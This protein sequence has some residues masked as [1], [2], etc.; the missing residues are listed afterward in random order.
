MTYEFQKGLLFK[1]NFRDLFQY[2]TYFHH[3]FVIRSHN[4]Q[5]LTTFLNSYYRKMKSGDLISAY[6]YNSQR[7]EVRR[8][9]WIERTQIS[10]FDFAE[11]TKKISTEPLSREIKQ[12]ITR[13]VIED[14][15]CNTLH[16]VVNFMLEDMSESQEELKQMVEEGRRMGGLTHIC[17]FFGSFK[18]NSISF[19]TGINF[20]RV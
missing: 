3:I 20:I 19:T 2:T 10:T 4:P 7:R 17:T 6:Y 14:T 15:Q 8:M 11:I 5:Q 9:K 13:K 16:Y 18:L 1:W 12:E